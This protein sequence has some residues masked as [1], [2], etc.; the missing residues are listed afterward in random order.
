VSTCGLE[1]VPRAVGAVSVLDLVGDLD[2]RGATEVMDALRARAESRSG[3]RVV[4]CDLSRLAV[5]HLKGLLAVFP[6]AQRR[7]GCWPRS[8]VHLAAPNPAL[9]RQLTR[10]GMPRFLPVHASIQD[11]LA[12]ARVEAGAVHLDLTLPAEPSSPCAARHAVTRLWPQDQGEPQDARQDA[13]LVA[14]ELVTNAVRHAPG[15]PLGVSL[16]LSPQRFVVAVTDTSRHE[17]ALRQVNS[18]TTGGRGL[19]L[20]AASS[21]T[22]GVRLVHRNGK[23]VW[24]VLDR[25]GERH[26]RTG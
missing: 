6:A 3:S 12:S 5:P 10:M 20:V 2:L 7:S 11:A 24:A 9:G 21:H 1:I 26:Q 4:V 15:P 8:S 18:A 25:T 17:P 22:W 14:S 23:T 16:T 19:H 13:L